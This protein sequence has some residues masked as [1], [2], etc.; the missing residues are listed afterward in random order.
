MSKVVIFAFIFI[1]MLNIT[2]QAPNFSRSFKFNL[3]RTVKKSFKSKKTFYLY[4]S[5]LTGRKR[6]VSKVDKEIFQNLNL[7]HLMTPSGLHL[8]SLLIIF[9]LLRRISKSP[10]LTYLEF[11][12]CLSIYIFLPGYY[13]LRR[14]AL[15]RTLFIVNRR[16][17]LSSLQVFSI[18]I[19]FDFIFGTYSLSPL[20]W[21]LSVMFLTI[22]FTRTKHSF[23]SL[24]T[25]FAMAQCLI[26]FI[27][28]QKFMTGSVFFSPIITWLFTGAYPLLVVNLPFIEYWNYAEPL[29]NF[30]TKM[31]YHSH[32]LASYFPV[33]VIGP[34]IVIA[35]IIINRRLWIFS[36]V[37]VFISLVWPSLFPSSLP[38]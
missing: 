32:E 35:M 22:I 16:L 10:Y 12:V 24:S 31:I 9:F 23:V 29:L 15:L 5:L 18:F 2:T 37:L 17:K 3:S 13:S 11:G 21:Y 33:I 25:S 27:F 14:I 19:V 7:L 6:G 28:K 30:F 34:L 8:S 4:R 36:G 38:T 26:A 1:S 20:S